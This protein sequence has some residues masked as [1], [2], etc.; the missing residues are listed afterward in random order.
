MGVGL[1]WARPSSEK[2]L[3]VSRLRHGV[4]DKVS[5][6]V[7]G[8]HLDWAPRGGRALAV[9]DGERGTVVSGDVEE[10]VEEEVSNA[11]SQVRRLDQG[12]RP[13]ALVGPGGMEA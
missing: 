1:C 13:D 8:G 10:G 3:G 12:G 6:P 2:A 11:L 5:P 9:R 7:D 4:S